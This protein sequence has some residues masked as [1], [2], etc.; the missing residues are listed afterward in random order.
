MGQFFQLQDIGA[1]APELEL[2]L[3]GLIILVADLLI[4]EK[5]RIGMIALAGIVLS[6]MFLYRLQGFET[7]AYGG[8]LV[9]DPF[10]S[11]FKLLF[12]S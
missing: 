6:G 11:F 12:S 4:Q 3:F 5:R 1:I 7:T 9:V 10:S 2:T 8:L